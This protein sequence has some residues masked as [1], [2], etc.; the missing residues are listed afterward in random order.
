ME[1][2]VS[3]LLS[4]YKN[5]TNNPTVVTK[6]ELPQ[7]K[8]DQN[9]TYQKTTVKKEGIQHLISSATLLLNKFLEFPRLKLSNSNAINL[10]GIETGLLLKNFVQHLKRKD[11]AIPDIYFVLLDAVSI[12]TDLVINSHAT[13]KE[14]GDCI[15]FKISRKKVA[16]ILHTRVC[17]IWLVEHFGKSS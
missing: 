14:R 1:Q 15:S 7:Y 4:L 2:F 12:T 13:A 11:V 9:P 10:D 5:N 8:T 3:V 16:Q 6:Q 17:S